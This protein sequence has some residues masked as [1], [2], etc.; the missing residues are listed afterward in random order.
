M[1]STPL[2]PL[3]RVPD[4]VGLVA[5]DRSVSV[6]A[7]LRISTYGALA[8]AGIVAAVS[9]AFLGS[10]AS[11]VSWP[12]ALALVAGAVWVPAAVAAFECLALL[13][14]SPLGL[15]GVHPT[16]AVTVAVVA[17]GTGEHV[18]QTLASV[19]S[20]DYGG[21]VDSLVVEDRRAVLER[22]TTPLVV[23]VDGGTVLHPSAVRLLV[24]RLETS[25]DAA[26]AVVTLQ[27]ARGVGD[28][29]FAEVLALGRAATDA[30]TRRVQT[31]FQGVRTVDGDACL[32]RTGALRAVGGWPDGES[33]EPALT[34]RLLEHGWQTLHEPLA[35]AFAFDDVDAGSLGRQR[36]RAARLLGRMRS[37]RTSAS[38]PLVTSRT[39]ETLDR[40]APWVDV[41]VCVG[42]AFAVVL[43]MLGNASLALWY[44]IGVM[45]PAVAW[46]VTARHKL[47]EALDDAGLAIPKGPL[48]WAGMLS[49]L[50]PA[51][52][53]ASAAVMARVALGTWST[54]RTRSGAKAT[55]APVSVVP[56]PDDGLRARAVQEDAR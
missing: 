25:P 33:P 49:A 1:E 42:G 20:Q 4:F 48:A 44:G 15:A 11:L 6:T 21:S 23:V 18:T 3:R 16:M 41:A 27:L 50:P 47:R 7:K 30:S 43:T 56:A 13:L 54:R 34:S 45:V 36:A 8:W 35:L 46:V 32:Y 55:S 22:V 9:T 10:L 37:E 31:L 24:S 12:V 51:V 29:P 19:A 2:P 53:P 40:L 26:A 5:P 14:D 39:L 52:A 38:F 28:H 17:R